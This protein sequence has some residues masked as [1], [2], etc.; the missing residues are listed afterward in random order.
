MV[1][2]IGVGQYLAVVRPGE[3]PS[4]FYFYCID[5]NP[6]KCDIPLLSSAGLAV[7]MSNA[8]DEV[9]GVIDYVTLNVDYNGIAAAINRFL[10]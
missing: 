4:L 2:I 10:L 6:M 8:P 9:K 7:A 5:N 1:H 3:S